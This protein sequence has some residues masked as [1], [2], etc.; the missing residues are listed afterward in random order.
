MHEEVHAWL[1]VPEPPGFDHRVRAQRRNGVG[2]DVALDLLSGDRVALETVELHRLCTGDH[3]RRDGARIEPQHVDVGE[4][5]EDPRVGQEEE[6][7]PHVVG[8]VYDERVLL[9]ECLS[10]PGP[11]E[12]ELARRK[13][14]LLLRKHRLELERADLA[15]AAQPEVACG[16]PLGEKARLRQP[17]RHVADFETLENLVVE[18][19]VIEVDVV[20]GGELAVLVVVD[21][22]DHPVGDRA[23]HLD[24]ELQIGLQLWEDSRVAPELDASVTRPEPRPVAS[25]LASPSD[26]DVEVGELGCESGNLLPRLLFGVRGGS[27]GGLGKERDIDVLSRTP[28]GGW[29]VGSCDPWKRNSSRTE[30]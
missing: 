8:V 11:G 23:A 14:S 9:Y 22:D 24:A 29:R 30:W 5:E 19:L 4:V 25:E 27:R 15:G 10:A 1:Q 6:L 12:T 7:T 26:T 16:N 13:V 28:S 18:P 17:E 2:L 3:R 20:G 21:V